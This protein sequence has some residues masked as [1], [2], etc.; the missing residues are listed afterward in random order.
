MIF[1]ITFLLAF[2]SIVYELLLAQAL[3]AFF[4]NTVLRYSVTIGLYMF[5]MGMGAMVMEKRYLKRPVSFL[6]KTEILLTSIG[7]FS[8]I[9]LHLLNI[10]NPKRI[11][12]LA[13][14]HIMIIIIGFLTGREIPLLIE[15]RNKE[16]KDSENTILG[17]DYTGALLGTVAFAFIFYPHMGLVPTAFL[18]GLLNSVTGI[19]LYSQRNKVKKE[20]ERQF[21]TNL[22]IQL[23]LCAVI[24]FCLLNADA[25]NKYF[26]RQ[27]LS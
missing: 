14:A 6:L 2:C 12:F 18:T 8:V 16:K 1:P 5:S 27:Y 25:I 23:F 11:I 13:L 4:E 10:L 9:I 15:I 3:S 21:Y 22:Y 7:G 17:I 20:A 19:L 26:I 24:T